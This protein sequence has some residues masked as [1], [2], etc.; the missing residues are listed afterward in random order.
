MNELLQNEKI[1]LFLCLSVGGLYPKDMFINEY[2]WDK[3]DLLKQKIIS[4]LNDEIEGEEFLN[5]ED[6]EYVESL[7]L[8]AKKIYHMDIIELK[9]LMK[10]YINN[11]GYYE[12]RNALSN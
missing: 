11:Y 10:I 4:C 1:D 5:I 12:I 6:E 7:R 9:E 2:R 3:S 8:I